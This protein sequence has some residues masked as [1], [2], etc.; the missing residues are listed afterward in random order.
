MLAVDWLGGKASETGGKLEEVGL[1]GDSGQVL[2]SAVLVV[3]VMGKWAI[4]MA[5]GAVCSCGKSLG[6]DI[7]PGTGKECSYW[8]KIEKSHKKKEKK[9]HVER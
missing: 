6:G 3:A 4:R 2:S 7:F 1:L 5:T 9:K 8:R